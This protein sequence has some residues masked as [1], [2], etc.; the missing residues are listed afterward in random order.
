MKMIE[1][2]VPLSER[3]GNFKIAD[4]L[5][6]NTWVPKKENADD[7]ATLTGKRRQSKKK[8]TKQKALT[9]EQMKAMKEMYFQI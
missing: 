1:H 8:D 7:S 5:M 6:K 2:P 4:T 9:Y 3:I